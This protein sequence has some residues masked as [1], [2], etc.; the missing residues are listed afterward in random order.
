MKKFILFLFLLSSVYSFSQNSHLALSMGPNFP[1]GDFAAIDD[2]TTNGYATNGFY[3]SFDGNY[4]PTWYFGIAGNISFGT[5][6]PNQDSMYS[7]LLT[8]LRDL[9]VPPLPEDLKKEF[10]I[11][12]W[13]YINLMV[14]PSVALPAGKFQFNA[15]ALI[16]MSVIIP[17]N[18]TLIV[19][20]NNKPVTG[21]AD[22]KDV[23]F[24]Y[25]VG[26]DIIF[27]L[28]SSYSIKVSADYFHTTIDYDVDFGFE[29][30]VGL[31]VIN[32]SFDINTINTTIGLAYLF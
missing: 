22:A 14:G 16:G 30:S 8:E 13:S 20:Y 17:P 23:S 25:S 12:S 11:G 18:Q 3:L 32:R 5:N 27:E 21:Y 9:N 7:S 2:Y 24:S 10:T 31:P 19:L 28:S 6:L 1:L 26:G 4:I 29:E 15:K